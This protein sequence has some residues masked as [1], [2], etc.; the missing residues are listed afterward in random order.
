MIKPDDVYRAV[1]DKWVARHIFDEVVIMPLCKSQDD[2]QYIYSISNETGSKV[3]QLLDGKH[4]VGDI[5]KSEY[6]GQKEVIEREVLEFIGDVFEAGLIEKSKET[7]S[8]MSN[9]LQQSTDKKRAYKTPEIAKVKMQP[10]QAVLAC[11][12][13]FRPKQGTPTAN[14]CSVG[15]CQ[16]T[17]PSCVLG[18]N[19]TYG[20]SG[21]AVIT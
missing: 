19:A 6:K 7:K 15:Q 8:T 21:G 4:S 2:M 5:L 10:E 16:F 13:Y 9:S 20:Y 14:T 18:Q 12:N 1:K 3:W 11:C 17:N